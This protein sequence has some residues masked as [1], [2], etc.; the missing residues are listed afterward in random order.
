MLVDFTAAWCI[1]C[2]VNKRVALHAASVVTALK[3]GKVRTL[4]AD[5]T[6]YD[7]EITAALARF[8]RSGVPL[9]LYYPSGATEPVILPELL[10]PGILLSTLE[11]TS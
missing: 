4:V 11:E 10:T 3:A 2:Q 9:Y 7:E 6:N 5:W 8:G 1:T